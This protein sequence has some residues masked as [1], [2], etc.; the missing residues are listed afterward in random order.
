MSSNPVAN[1]LQGVLFKAALEMPM[2]HQESMLIEACMAVLGLLGELPQDLMLRVGWKLSKYCTE[3]QFKIE[4]A[5][6]SGP[7]PPQPQHDSPFSGSGSIVPFTPRE[8]RA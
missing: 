3:L 4:E 5:R 6:E 7:T 1:H 8:G 2:T